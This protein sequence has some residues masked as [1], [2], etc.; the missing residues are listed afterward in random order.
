[1]HWS[2]LGLAE[3]RAVDWKT[4]VAALEK[5]SKLRSAGNGLDWSILAMAHWQWSD[6][7]EAR[8]WYSK[9]VARMEQAGCR[10]PEHQ[11]FA[12]E[13]AGLLGVTPPRLGE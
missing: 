8:V 13:A 11:H 12:R 10:N 1:V 4:T 5:A 3:Y 7:Q 6:K 2:T 9:T